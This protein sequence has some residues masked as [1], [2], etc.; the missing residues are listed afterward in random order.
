M[1]L[2]LRLMLLLLTMT[3]KRRRHTELLYWLLAQSS[4]K[5]YEL[6]PIL[7]QF[8]GAHDVNNLF[9]SIKPQNS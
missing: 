3:I 4:A 6:A 8:V 2:T 1:C 5:M 7:V 9:R